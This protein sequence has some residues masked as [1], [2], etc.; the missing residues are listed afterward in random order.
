MV[1][2]TWFNLTCF[3]LTRFK[4]LFKTI[5]V[6]NLFTILLERL[7]ELESKPLL[8][9]LDSLGG[10]PVL[11]KDK[12]NESDWSWEKTLLKLHEFVG[13]GDTENLFRTKT[14]QMDKDDI[15]RISPDPEA[16]KEDKSTLIDKYPEYM[17]DM[18]ILLG[19]EN[20]DETKQELF[21]ALELGLALNQL[22][23]GSQF[24][25][26]SNVI[27]TKEL[28]VELEL[29]KWLELFDRFKLETT[30]SFI[31]NTKVHVFD[32]LKK[33]KETFKP[34]VFA[35]YILWRFVDF[36]TLFLHNAALDQVLT[37]NRQIYGL[38]DK[39]QRWKFC[40]RMSNQYAELAA[41]SMYVEQYFPEESRIAATK[42]SEKIIEEL[43]RT[44]Q[45]ADW[46]D[47]D[48]KTK[49]FNTL[50]SLRVYM[51]YD[52]KLLDIKEVENYYG[53]PEKDFSD[54][55]LYLCLQLNVLKADKKFKHK[56]RNETDWTEYAKPT[57][58][59]AS[60]NSRDN[61]ICKC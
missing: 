17:F 21:D 39:E 37:L 46:M 14:F 27:D 54:G 58:S 61:T 59:K 43:K 45:S 5:F 55:F 31:I 7:K 29:L 34:R 6:T 41:G 32:N 3:N 53:K 4:N 18:A 44:V 22:L 2:L 12:W 10:W 57:S 30:E 50:N 51:G 24:K 8:D 33:L 11:M 47:K 15:Q 35:N 52:A 42:M 36:S 49:A 48:S 40:S 26:T 38:L 19:A 23:K 56:Y 20:S 9:L 16:V 1:H 25:R 28:R 13:V 60:Y